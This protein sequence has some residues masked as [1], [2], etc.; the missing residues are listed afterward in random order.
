MK[1]KKEVLQSI[2]DAHYV[3]HEKMSEI[4]RRYNV[5]RQ[6][7]YLALKRA[8]HNTSRQS[9]KA[10]CFQCGKEVSRNRRRLNKAIHSFCCK[11]CYYA[12]LKDDKSL[13]WRSGMRQARKLVATVFPL[14]SGYVVHHKDKDTTNNVLTNLMVFDSQSSHIRHH[15]GAIVTPL[16]DGMATQ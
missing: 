5:S 3:K 12:Y 2:L 15:R 8:G 9:Y 13:P 4:A 16:Y 6:A 14:L 7:I 1:I 11:P 10:I